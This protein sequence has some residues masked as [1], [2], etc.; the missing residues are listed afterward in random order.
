MS[1]DAPIQSWELRDYIAQFQDNQL[2]LIEAVRA[3]KPAPVEPPTAY[4]QYFK[5]NDVIEQLRKKLGCVRVQSEARGENLRRAQDE[6]D[7]MNQ[8]IADQALTIGTLRDEV[9][10][11]REARMAECNRAE[12]AE[13]ERDAQAAELKR[14]REREIEVECF[15]KDLQFLIERHPDTREIPWNKL[16]ARIA[17]VRDFKL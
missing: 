4:I 1:V 9:S 13:M 3:L 16:P 8:V 17:A 11:V 2:A 12:A 5:E 6:I 15:W 10:R 7:R 14:F